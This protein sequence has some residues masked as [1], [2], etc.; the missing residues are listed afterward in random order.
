MVMKKIYTKTGDQGMTSLRGGQ[1]VPK[2]DLRIEANGTLDELN[3]LLGLVRTL[4]PADSKAQALL[5][6]VQSELMVVMSHVA[7]PPPLV[8][9]RPL[10]ADA[11]TT[12]LEQAMDSLAAS[13]PAP[14]GF[15]LP[16]GTPL[17]AGLHVARTV[18]RRAERRLWT[19]HRQS[20]LDPSILRLVN[21]LSDLCYVMARAEMYRHGHPEE[22]LNAP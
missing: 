3:A 18:A 17:S 10:H 20:P 5:H 6:G 12:Q 8:N 11:L 22:S 4:L 13:C 14:S 21:R 19:L 2:D 1:R 9:P 16:G 15:V 7:T